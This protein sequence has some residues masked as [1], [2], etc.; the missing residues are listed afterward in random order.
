MGPRKA[1]PQSQC[2]V[3][4]L[5]SFYEFPNDLPSEIL[6]NYTNKLGWIHNREFVVSP[7]IDM[8]KLNETEILERL[9]MY[10]T[11]TFEKNGVYF[12]CN[13]WKNLLSI[14]EPIYKEWCLEFFSTVSF[15]A[16]MVDPH[17]VGALVIRLHSH[18]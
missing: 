16:N 8:A 4:N 14:K 2:D 15:E 13:G 17:F 3:S 18:Y 9:N 10:L 12:T 1:T 6:N 7:T 5:H 11:K